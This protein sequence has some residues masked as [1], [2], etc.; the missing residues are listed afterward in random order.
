MQINWS[1]RSAIKKNIFPPFRKLTTKDESDSYRQKL[2]TIRLVRNEE[3][4]NVLL[5]HRLPLACD[6]K[7]K[8][9]TNPGGIATYARSRRIPMLSRQLMTRP[10]NNGKGKAYLQDVDDAHEVYVGTPLPVHLGLQPPVQTPPNSAGKTRL[11]WGQAWC[12]SRSE[13]I[14]KDDKRSQTCKY[15]LK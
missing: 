15:N 10:T 2:S 4:P 3:R 1:R 6:N 5:C 7:V 11:R 9:E 13:I 14:T 12:W 8:A